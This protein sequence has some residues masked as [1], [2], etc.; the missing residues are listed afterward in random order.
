MGRAGWPDAIYEAEYAEMRI[1]GT[2]IV[3]ENIDAQLNDPTRFS[4]GDPHPLFAWLRKNDPVRWTD[5][6][7]PRPYWSVTRHADCVDILRQPDVFSSRRGGLMPLEAADPDPATARAMG[8]GVIPT[9][10]DPPRHMHIRRPFNKHFS[11]AT[12]AAME[13]AVQ[14]SVDEAIAYFL[15]RD[16]PDVVEDLAARLPAN[17]VCEMMGVPE[18]DRPAIQY[19][20]AAFMASQDPQYQI[21][22]DEVKTQRFMMK[23][24]FDYM[25]ALA[26]ERRKK[27]ADDFTSII[28][29]MEIDGE[30]LS[31]EDIGWWCFSIVAAG[32]E[33]TRDALSV[34]FLQ[35]FRQPEQAD[36]LRKSDKYLNLAADEFVRWA[37]PALQKF[38]IATRDY[39][40]GGQTIREGDWVIAWLVSANRDEEVFE[41]PYQFDITRSPNKHIAFGVGEHS[42]LGRHLARMEMNKM[43]KRFVEIMPSL[44]IAGDPQ[45]VISNSH[46]GLKS[47]PVRFVNRPRKAA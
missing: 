42:C 1:E 24:L 19:K 5:G 34:G 33:T 2:M 6:N 29:N 25:F 18:A 7:S 32:L 43:T 11:A 30:P 14:R 39:A 17:L 23:A 38:R 13:P 37:N 10:T 3:P 41:N 8:F 4:D 44:E 26:M 36:L 9:H 28:A 16:A 27:P 22:G 15:D 46:T 47:L 20:C 35:L 45:W 31:D 21:D 12:I 40:I